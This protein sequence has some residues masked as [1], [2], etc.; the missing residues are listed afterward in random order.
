MGL[1]GEARGEIVIDARVGDAVPLRPDGPPE[2]EE[3]GLYHTTFSSRI[4]RPAD[5]RS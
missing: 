1:E 4:G 3:R 5:I 2:E